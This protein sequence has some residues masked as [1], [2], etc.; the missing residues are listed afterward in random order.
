MVFEWQKSKQCS[1]DYDQPLFTCKIVGIKLVRSF[2]QWTFE[3]RSVRS[4]DIYSHT[5]NTTHRLN[6]IYNNIRTFCRHSNIGWWVS[7]RSIAPRVYHIIALIWPLSTY[8]RHNFRFTCTIF[9]WITLIKREYGVT[10][11]FNWYHCWMTDTCMVLV[12]IQTQTPFVWKSKIVQFARP[13]NK[14][15][16]SQTFIKLNSKFRGKFILFQVKLLRFN[17]VIQFQ[18]NSTQLVLFN[19]IPLL[20]SWKNEGN[21]HQVLFR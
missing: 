9:A 21:S 5:H 11:H 16:Q 3:L 15:C 14:L 6:L 20:F 2:V 8:S 13:S 7:G 4:G 19:S 10:R 18:S 17:K 1:T 12:A